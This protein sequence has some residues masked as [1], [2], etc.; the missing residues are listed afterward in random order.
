MLTV[1]SITRACPVS[2]LGAEN[3]MGHLGIHLPD[4]V[5]IWHWLFLWAS[6]VTFK[7]DDPFDVAYIKLKLPSFGQ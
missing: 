1:D 5:M 6:H 3:A 7:I 2:L 4:T